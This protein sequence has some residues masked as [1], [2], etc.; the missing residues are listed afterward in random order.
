M[1]F[2][3]A[4]IAEAK[5]REAVPEGPYDV[6]I[7]SAEM[8]RSDTSGKDSVRCILNIPEQP[9]AAGIF[10]YIALP[11]SDDD[12]EKRNMKLVMM[13]KFL[14]L[15]H[16]PFEGNGFDTDDLIGAAGRVFL[17]VENDNND[18]PRNNVTFKIV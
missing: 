13:K 14:E 15:L 12:D 16:V 5:E 1:G 4:A 9:D 6:V 10:H 17:N 18:I 7:A 11:H 3:E 2:I 8:H